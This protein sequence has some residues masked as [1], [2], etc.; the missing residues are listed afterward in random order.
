MTRSP[1]TQSNSRSSTATF[2]RISS[3]KASTEDSTSCRPLTT[4]E[5]HRRIH[6][7]RDFVNLK[8]FN[9]SVNEVVKR[10]PDGAP[11]RLIAQALMI[12]EDDVEAMWPAIVA[13]L[14]GKMGVA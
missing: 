13:K 6:E 10:Y 1:R 11:N 9:Y 3:V 7:D 2:A 12:T 14:R 8:R 5:A 4:D